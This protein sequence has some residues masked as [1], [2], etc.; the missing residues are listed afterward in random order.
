MNRSYSLCSL[1]HESQFHTDHRQLCKYAAIFAYSCRPFTPP[2]ETSTGN[3][4]FSYLDAYVIELEINANLRRYGSGCK[5]P[6]S[7]QAV[8]E[9]GCNKLPHANSPDSLDINSVVRGSRS[10]SGCDATSRPNAEYK[11]TVC[12]P[13]M[14]SQSARARAGDKQLTM[15]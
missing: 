10:R 4:D 14:I 3:R 13:Q 6:F 12:W 1:R 2:D 11:S 15:R 7:T 9:T 5:P 8:E